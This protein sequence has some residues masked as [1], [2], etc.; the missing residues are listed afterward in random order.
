MDISKS[1]LKQ[2]LTIIVFIAT[3]GFANQNQIEQLL[4]T[5]DKNKNLTGFIPLLEKQSQ[6]SFR[7][8]GI[9]N[10]IAVHN[11]RDDFSSVLIDSSFNGFS[12]ISDV[13]DPLAWKPNAGF[14]LTYR[15]FHG[16]QNSSGIIGAAQS[17]DGEE[18]FDQS[19]LNDCYPT[20]DCEPNL[21]TYNGLQVGRYPSSFISGNEDNNIANVIWNEYTNSQLGGGNAGGYCAP[22]KP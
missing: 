17:Q 13:N 14:V 11:S 8:T 3:F 7:H 10:S 5:V 4:K 12:F 1:F 18:W 21:P 22:D 6:N 2:V 15:R 9:S 16:S 20:G 19:Y